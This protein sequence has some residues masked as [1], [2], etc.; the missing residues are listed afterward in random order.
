MSYTAAV[1]AFP[2]Y[3]VP[4]YAYPTSSYPSSGTAWMAKLL[5]QLEKTSVTTM[6][7][8]PAIWKEGIWEH[9]PLDDLIS[10]LEE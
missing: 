10:R 5:M 2:K 7:W 8:E 4:M 1:G 9:T 3:G 6:I